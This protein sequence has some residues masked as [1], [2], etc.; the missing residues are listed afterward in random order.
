VTIRAYNPSRNAPNS[1]QGGL[2]E[3]LFNPLSFAGNFLFL[4]E[5][6]YQNE[7]GFVR[8]KMGM[9]NIEILDFTYTPSA[10]LLDAPTSFHL[11]SLELNNISAAIHLPNNKVAFD[12]LLGILK[13]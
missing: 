6:E 4:Q 12:K 11:T 9:K 8:N 1:S 5:F 2:L 10:K 7:L 13:R 3:N